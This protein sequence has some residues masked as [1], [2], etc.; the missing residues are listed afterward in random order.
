MAA[1]VAL[2]LFGKVGDHAV[3]REEEPGDGRGVLERRASPVHKLPRIKPEQ[4]FAVE[5]FGIDLGIRSE[6][7]EICRQLRIKAADFGCIKTLCICSFTRHLV[8]RRRGRFR[9]LHK[10]QRNLRKHLQPTSFATHGEK[11]VRR[12]SLADQRPRFQPCRPTKLV[13][14]NPAENGGRWQ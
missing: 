14:T 7:A 4:K 9:A 1:A 3:G 8:D 10:R 5:R 2:L 12:S 11:P 13:K 6:N